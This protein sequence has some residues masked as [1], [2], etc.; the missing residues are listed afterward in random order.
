MYLFR[1]TDL[2]GLLGNG[3]SVRLSIFVQFEHVDDNFVT[4][5]YFSPHKLEELD[6]IDNIRGVGDIPV[7]E[8]WFRSARIGRNRRD[9]R[10]NGPIPL[11]PD[12]PTLP[13]PSPEVSY[14]HHSPTSHHRH[15]STSSYISTSS[16]PSG[17]SSSESTSPVRSINHDA[18]QHSLSQLVPLEILVRTSG[19]RRDPADEQTLRRFSS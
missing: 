18:S 11:S 17:Y 6:T 8:G 15:P 19:P 7:P 5:A 9:S 1:L 14:H 13:P 16:S 12:V 10:T 2:E 3:I 4:A